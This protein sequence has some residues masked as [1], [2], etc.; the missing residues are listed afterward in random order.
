[1]GLSRNESNSIL[2]ASTGIFAD[3][4]RGGWCV[5]DLLAIRSANGSPLDVRK[6]SNPH[7]N[8][9]PEY[10]SSFSR[11]LELRTRGCR[12]LLVSGTASIDDHGSSVHE[13]DF[14]KQTERTLDTV[15]A[16]LGVGGGSFGD[17]RQATAFVKRQEDISQLRNILAR[18]GME[19]LPV[20]YTVG[21]VCRDELLFELDATAVVPKAED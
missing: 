14:E 21:D 9:A 6:L 11:G 7:Q 12:Y 5:L 3:N 2:P 15:E 10:G 18:R 1:M 20:V 16:L 13:N 17:V 19:E 4:P 8:E